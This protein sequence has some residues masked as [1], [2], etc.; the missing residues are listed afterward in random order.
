MGM[1]KHAMHLSPFLLVDNC[2]LELNIYFP[3]CLSL[4]TKYSFKV[5]QGLV[6][7][8]IHPLNKQC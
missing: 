2:I 8:R 1:F 3:L 7:A 5:P 4:N 6:L